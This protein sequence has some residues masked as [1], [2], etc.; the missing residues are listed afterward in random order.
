MQHGDLAAA[1]S[2]ELDR[3]EPDWGRTKELLA[4]SHPD[5]L[6]WL[7]RRLARLGRGDADGRTSFGDDAGVPFDLTTSVESWAFDVCL[8]CRTLV[9]RDASSAE[10]D[11]NRVRLRRIAGDDRVVN[12][13]QASGVR[14][15]DLDG[16][17]L[18]RGRAV[19][20]VANKDVDLLV[21]LT[22]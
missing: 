4:Y 8:T 12:K 18:D 21:W 20:D 9:E 3:S 10:L 7:V 1:V 11:L 15:I 5:L 6:I 19:H 22:G 16:A 2:G 13:G 17:K 14:H